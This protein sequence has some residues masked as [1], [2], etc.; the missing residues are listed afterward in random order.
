VENRYVWTAQLASPEGGLLLIRGFP[1][2]QLYAKNV[3]QDG[4]E[5]KEGA[6]Q[7]LFAAAK[8]PAGRVWA[9][10]ELPQ[11]KPEPVRHLQTP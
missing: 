1:N 7:E 11:M 5:I 3:I 2:A 10:L 4:L 6:C 8:I 9:R